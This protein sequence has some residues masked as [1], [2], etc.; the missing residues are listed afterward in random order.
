MRKL[1]CTACDA[2]MTWRGTGFSWEGDY[3]ITKQ[4]WECQSSGC[5]TSA[6][7]EWRTFIPVDVARM[8]PAE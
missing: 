4:Q 1:P 7:V 5:Q 6:T 3:E 8:R 2:D